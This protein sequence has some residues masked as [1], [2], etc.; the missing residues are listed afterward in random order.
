MDV[1]IEKETEKEPSGMPSIL[2]TYDFLLRNSV[3]CQ[4]MYSQ[5]ETFISRSRT[6]GYTCHDYLENLR[7][8]Q[9]AIVEHAPLGAL[10]MVFRGTNELEDWRTN[11]LCCG[12]GD[13]AVF[14][15]GVRQALHDEGFITQLLGKLS[16]ALSRSPN[17]KLFITGHSL[18]GVF[19]EA[20]AHEIEHGDVHPCVVTF[21]AP[22]TFTRH[23]L[24]G[25][26]PF[27]KTIRVTHGDDIVPCIPIPCLY[28]RSDKLHVPSKTPRMGLGHCCR[29]IKDHDVSDYVRAMAE[30]LL[31]ANSK[32]SR[33][34]IRHR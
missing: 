12:C 34:F 21:G 15:V 7:G 1:V 17:C 16:A 2:D 11:L 5:K 14:S 31:D 26:T 30:L 13:A 23:G 10:H 18:G 28:H 19:A 4:H 24:D 33:G 32:Q 29:H 3:L 27:Y 20:A 6:S 25:T 22:K 8:V 9:V